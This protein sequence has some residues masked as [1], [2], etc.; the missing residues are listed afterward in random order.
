MCDEPR[1]H[2]ISISSHLEYVAER[3]GAGGES[4]HE[5]GLKDPFAIVEAV[6]YAGKAAMRDASWVMKA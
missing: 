6:A 2:A 4:V 5:H 1:K 3:H